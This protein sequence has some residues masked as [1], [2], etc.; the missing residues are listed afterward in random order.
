MLETLRERLFAAL[1]SRTATQATLDTILDTVDAEKRSAMTSDESAA[2]AEARDALTPIDATIAELRE[3]I[4]ALEDVAKRSAD[5]AAVAA[6][7]EP[8]ATATTVRVGAEPLTYRAG[9]DAPSFIADAY[10]HQFNADPAASARITRHA[11]EMAVEYRSAGTS[12]FTTGLVVPQYLVDQFAPLARAGRPFLDSLSSVAL[13]DTGMTLNIPRLTTGTSVDAQASQNGSISLTDPAATLL[14]VNVNTYSGES[15]LSRQSVERGSGVMDIVMRDLIAAYHTSIDA[16]AINGAGT[17][18][19]HTGVLN[20]SGINSV[21]LSTATTVALFPKLADAIQRINSARYAAANLIVMHPRRWGSLLASLD[22]SNRPLIQTATPS[23]NAMGSGGNVGAGVVGQ[24]LGVDVV[25]DANIPT[26]LG[27]GTNED[28]IIVMKKED[29]LVFE[30]A[31]SPLGLR[32]EQ[33]Y[34]NTLTVDAV[35]YGYSA[36]V[37]GSRFPAGVSVI[38]GAGLVTPTF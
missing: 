32:F 28:R 5:A 2:F 36:M 17:S 7:L 14:T 33:T 16:A 15:R 26:N 18:G 11:Q 12:A 8:H 25:L 27:T 10:A 21:T 19:T 3:Q 13:A 23:F 35:V 30:Q 34:G 4:T 20:V 9:P 37:I 38:S 31:G 6:A 22:S 29:S 24:I 1:E